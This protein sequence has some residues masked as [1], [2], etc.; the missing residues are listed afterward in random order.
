MLVRQDLLLMNPN[1][2]FEITEERVLETPV[3]WRGYRYI[4]TFLKN[5]T[6]F[7]MLGRHA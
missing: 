5:R 4:G 7:Y 1:W 2:S 6:I 3:L